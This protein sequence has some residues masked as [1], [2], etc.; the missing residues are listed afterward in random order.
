MSDTRKARR[1]LN[2][3]IQG[4]NAYSAI[5]MFNAICEA[6]PLLDRKKPEF[7]VKR[8]ARGPLSFR[9]KLLCRRLRDGGMPVHEI[10]RRVN[11]NQGRVSEAL[12]EL[13]DV[14]G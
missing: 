7:K 3:A 6:L 12:K 1:I 2:G 5:T 11:K 14:E 13:A 10:A 8:T 9:E 4:D